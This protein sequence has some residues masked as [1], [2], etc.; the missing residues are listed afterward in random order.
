MFPF[1]DVVMDLGVKQITCDPG[2][3][4]LDLETWKMTVP[5][6][7][8]L[9]S[10]VH[11]ISKVNTPTKYVQKQLFPE[12]NKA[13]ATDEYQ[14]NPTKLIDLS[15][16][17]DIDEQYGI[18]ADN[19]Q[20][21]SVVEQLSKPL[22]AVTKYLSEHD[23]LEKWITFC[24][25]VSEGNFN[26]NNI[27]LQLF[28]DVVKFKKNIASV[29]CSTPVI[30]DSNSLENYGHISMRAKKIFEENTLENFLCHT[31]SY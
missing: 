13:K 20:L 16:M 5:T 27:A 30:I 25:L 15:P 11:K 24:H 29:D 7:D 23:K 1:D 3:M 12:E 6:T 19:E 28:W 17:P 22:P 18:L 31:D 21:K 2:C 10:P 14:N 26:L 4:Q 8:N 9:Q